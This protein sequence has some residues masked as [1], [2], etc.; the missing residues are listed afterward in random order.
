MRKLFF[1]FCVICISLALTTCLSPWDGDSG[2]LTIYWGNAKGGRAWTVTDNLN[3]DW[4]SFTYT[5]TLKGPGTTVEETFANGVPGATFKLPVGTWGVTIKGSK[6]TFGIPEF[7]IMGIE[8]IEVKAGKKTAAQVTMC[9]AYEVTDWNEL[10]NSA[11]WNVMSSDRP[12]MILIANDLEAISPIIFSSTAS[13][14][15]SKR[16][17]FIVAEKDVVIDKAAG[18]GNM[19]FEMGPYA[20]YTLHLGKPGMSGTITFDNKGISN[21]ASL[22]QIN[23]P[24]TLEMNDGVTIKGGN[25]STSVGAAV[26]LNNASAGASYFIMNGGIISDNHVNYLSPKGGGVVVGSY[27]N[28]IQNGGIFKNNTQDNV[29]YQ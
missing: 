24:S 22:I 14:A 7:F 8:Q 26:N 23:S 17:W 20:D 6:G 16:E 28:F 18:N 29:Y 13:G 25:F 3:D 11:A 1:G 19:F 9:N 21:F 12:M 27:G 2:N 5:V 10:S 15:L 4:K